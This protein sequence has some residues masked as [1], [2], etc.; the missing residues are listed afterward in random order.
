MKS[1]TVTAQ[2]EKIFLHWIMSHSHFF[3]V[4]DGNYFK[5]EEIKFIYNA[6]RNEWLSSDDKVVPGIKE[7][8]TMVRSL[9]SEEK[10]SNDL[11]STILKSDPKDYRDEFIDGRFKAWLLS[12]S[13]ITGLVDAIEQ[14]KNVDR[15]N[16]DEVNEKV[17]KVKYII[18]EKTTVDLGD[19]NI[20]I[21]FDDPD[22]HNQE[23]DVYKMS[24][25]YTCL[26]TMLGGGWDRKTLNLFVG[27]PGSGK[28]CFSSTL[29]TIKNKVTGH[30]ENITFEEF[31]NKI[32][33][34]I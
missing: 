7:I 28:C 10:I 23:V 15:I 2:L 29:I 17:E 1:T 4:V 13:T 21:D 16:F 5:N 20:G 24:S 14:I 34:N 32:N 25:G 30:I 6:I 33:K 22:A 19:N 3:K 27:S 26:N 18:N 9:D 12:N 31:Y 11:L 8:K